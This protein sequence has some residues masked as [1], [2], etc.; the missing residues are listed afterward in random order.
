MTLLKGSLIWISQLH[1]ITTENNNIRVNDYIF[2]F[3]GGSDLVQGFHYCEM[4]IIFVSPSF[5]NKILFDFQ[6]HET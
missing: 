3:Y 2:M 6:Q 1:R 4:K 5:A